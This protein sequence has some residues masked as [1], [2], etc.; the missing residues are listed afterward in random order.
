MLTPFFLQAHQ[1]RLARHSY[2]DALMKLLVSR[3]KSRVQALAEVKEGVLELE[4]GWD[5]EE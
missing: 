1:D 2:L 3:K 5:K 4:R